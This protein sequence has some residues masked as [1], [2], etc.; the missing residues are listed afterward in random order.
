MRNEKKILRFLLLKRSAS[1]FIGDTSFSF[2]IQHRS[3]YR[4]CNISIHEYN[5]EV[6]TANRS[7]T[8]NY[9][10]CFDRF[11]GTIFLDILQASKYNV[12]KIFTNK[13]MLQCY[14]RSM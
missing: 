2:I 10:N 5:L 7:S 4:K 11:Y 8:R 14:G 9:M 13:C 6:N 12:L 3:H 1:A